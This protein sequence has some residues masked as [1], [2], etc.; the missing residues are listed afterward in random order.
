MGEREEKTDFQKWMTDFVYSY[1]LYIHALVIMEL[2][3]NSGVERFII[4]A[5][6]ALAGGSSGAFGFIYWFQAQTL[7]MHG[8]IRI[9]TRREVDV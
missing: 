6:S 8:R 1:M 2:G 3:H 7:H 4:R 5:P 9:R